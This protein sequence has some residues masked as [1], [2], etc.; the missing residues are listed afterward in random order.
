MSNP[1]GLYSRMNAQ[2]KTSWYVRV[3]LHGRMQHFGSFPS[4]RA[5]QEFYDRAKYLRREQRL[6]PGQTIPIEYTIPELFAAYLPDAEHR[7]AYREQKR[8]ADWWTTYWP[9][10]RVFA[11]TPQHLQQARTALRTS[12]RFRK[13]SEATVNHYMINLRHAML[14]KIQPR[15]WVID[16]WSQIKLERPPG[17]LPVPLLREDEAKLTKHLTADDIDKMRLGL[18]TGLRRAQIFGLQWERVYWTKCGVSLPTLKRQRERFL[19]FPTPAM[20]ILQRRWTKAGRPS[21]GPVFPHPEHP[22]LHEDANAWYKN[23]FKPAIEAAGLRT[24]GLKFH[25]TRHGFADR[26]LEAGGNTRA[27]QRAGGWS[28]LSQV[29]RYTQL[30]DEQVR[31]GMERAANLE[32]Q[33]IKLQNRRRSPRGK[34]A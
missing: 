14:E 7:R 24:K 11:L 28:S 33:W 2:G 30:Q 6:T 25:S 23:N 12:G 26:F 29:E 27:L 10:Q 4:Q 18:L 3:A 8:F 13:R 1:R 15:S 21:T 20:T 17:A 19:S 9:H 5:A 16:L 22:H 32:T 31:L 34:R